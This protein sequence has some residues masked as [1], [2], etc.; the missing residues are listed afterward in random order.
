MRLH[1]KA[2]KT[3]RGY[4]A[5]RVIRSVKLALQGVRPPAR[6]QAA[7]HRTVPDLPQPLSRRERLQIVDQ[8]LRILRDTYAHLRMKQAMHAI[9]PIG[10]LELLRRAVPKSEESRFDD[11]QFHRE[12]LDIFFS[13][14]DRHTVYTLPDYWG[15]RI[16]FLPFM[17]EEITERSARKY[18]VS[19]ILNHARSSSFAEGVEIVSWNGV[20]IEQAVWSYAQRHAGSNL[21]ARRAMGLLNLTLRALQFD[22]PP[23]ER[24]VVVEYRLGGRRGKLQSRKFDWKIGDDPWPSARRPRAHDGALANDAKLATVQNA[25]LAMY[26][27]KPKAR[28]A[29]RPV[30]RSVRGVS[31]TEMK[32]TSWRIFRARTYRTPDG[33]FG[34]IR[35]WKFNDL[36]EK[37]FLQEFIDLLKRMPGEGLIIDIRGNPGGKINLAEVILQTLTPARIYPETFQF[38]NTPLTL[39]ICVKAPESEGLAPWKES[40]EEGL[41]TGAIYSAA[42]PKSNEKRCNSIPQQYFGPA[43]L[44]TDALTY[45]A[46]DIFAAGFQDHK[47]GPVLGTH[48]TTG[49]GGANR[50]NYDKLL[51]LNL[52]GE[53]FRLLPGGAGFHVAVRRSLRVLGKNGAILEDFGVKADRRHYMTRDDVLNDNVDLIRKAGELLRK[54]RAPFD[55]EIRR[56]QQA[57]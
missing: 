18:I 17:V 4:E 50:W 57:P 39:D 29:G 12:M 11:E 20:P 42:F 47:I 45:S 7:Q 10:R 51:S 34:Y 53:P 28:R 30:T 2:A 16:A 36:G 31:F 32:T 49:A 26:G 24:W 19:K 41:A 14:R 48:D 33:T 5:P 3:N 46:G 55:L 22:P 23:D 44:I 21:D 13:L 38:R 8:G 52:R 25:R 6:K 15:G 27:G 54:R 1:K 37:Q 56:M 9:D 40:I 43:V 35:I